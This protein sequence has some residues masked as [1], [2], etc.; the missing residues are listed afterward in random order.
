MKRLSALC[1]LCAFLATALGS[2]ASA[3]KNSAKETDT[4]A[5]FSRV[6]K[7]ETHLHVDV[8]L[9]TEDMPG[10]DID[11]AS[12]MK[13]AG[14]NAV[15]MTFAVDYVPLAEKGRRTGVF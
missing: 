9:R 14:M 7:T 13:K 15:V 10:A 11:L 8:P 6:T 2:C 3:Q 1:A 4:D 12:A 5:I